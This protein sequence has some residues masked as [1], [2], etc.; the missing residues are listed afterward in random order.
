M[1]ED[2][3]DT[4]SDE[5]APPPDGVAGAE[6]SAT[7]TWRRALRWVENILLVVLALWA[8]NR[9][10]PQL[11]AWVGISL[12]AE[13][14]PDVELVS[15]DGEPFSL[16]AHRGQV[17]L[18][19]FWATWCRPCRVEMRGFEKVYQKYRDRGF[20]IVGISTDAGGVQG[21]RSFVA[22]RGV[23][24]PVAMADRNVR[25]EFGGVREIPTSFLI[26]RSGQIRYTVRG[27]WVGPAL[28][29]AVGRLVE[30]PVPGGPPTSD[31]SP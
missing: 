7:P 16:A 21:V 6:A 20:T 14:S 8:F 23:S 18:V 10:G 5:Q 2:R 1:S 4:E 24:Y 30:E 28:G 11:A 13:P 25:R 17:V 3:L 29:A 26:D 15:L 31:P 12:G 22:E 9:V 19:N 27:L